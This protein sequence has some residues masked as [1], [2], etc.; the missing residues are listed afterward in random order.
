VNRCQ[1][2]L[3]IFSFRQLS[4]E[5]LLQ[6]GTVLTLVEDLRLAEAV[7]L[8]H[9]SAVRRVVRAFAADDGCWLLL[10]RWNSNLLLHRA[11]AR[12]LAVFG[13]K[14]KSSKKIVSVG[15]VSAKAPLGHGDLLLF[16]LSLGSDWI[17]LMAHLT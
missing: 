14:A 15:S 3:L 5:V 7:C 1:V 16:L 13:R 11:L 10:L 2:S 9:R 17:Q 4:L 6:S 8:I 12:L